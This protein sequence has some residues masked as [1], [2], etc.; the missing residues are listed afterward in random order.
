MSYNDRLSPLE[1][2]GLCGDPERIDPP[3]TLRSQAQQLAK[4][5]LDSNH[6]V[7]FTGAGI[8]TAVGIPDFRGP[9][10]IWTLQ[11]QQRQQQQQQQQRQQRSH[12]AAP[13]TPSST[14][15]TPTPSTQPPPPNLFNSAP[16]SL[17]H[18]CLVA[19]HR[20]TTPHRLLH[21]TITQNVDNLHTKSGLPRAHTT[22]LH[23]NIFV[24]HCRRCHTH[25]YQPADVGGMG[26][27]VVGGGVRCEWCGGE[28]VDNAVDWTTPLP[29]REFERAEA[30][31]RKAELV[32]VLGSSLRI[33]PASGLPGMCRWKKGAKGKGKVGGMG[34][35]TGKLVIINLQKTHMDDKC[36][37]RVWGKCD[38]V[39]R[40]VC[41]E[42]GVEIGEWKAGTPMPPYT[43]P[44]GT[45]E[46]EEDEAGEE[47]QELAKDNDWKPGSR[48]GSGS[49]KRKS[50][51]ATEETRRRSE[52]KRKK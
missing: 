30:E 16:P 19:L 7:A 8:S 35:R 5:I 23:G 22:E 33:Q 27:R 44:E 51:P 37:L 17:T 43:F 49:R 29:R 24:L 25:F 42:L 14:S 4:L 21:H 39:M 2:K 12:T 32:I 41:E 47:E 38:D 18:L 40:M 9:K 31:C 13:A 15:P 26:R 48:Q 20:T 52:R 11:Q 34:G 45:E 6:T 3:L 1:D 28:V 46:E 36:E 10:G 50:L